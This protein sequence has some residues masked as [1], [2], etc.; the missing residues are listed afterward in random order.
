M[1]RRTATPPSDF[2]F[3]PRSADKEA[4]AFRRNANKKAIFIRKSLFYVLGVFYIK[5]R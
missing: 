1:R 2:L 4:I 5:Q 3:L